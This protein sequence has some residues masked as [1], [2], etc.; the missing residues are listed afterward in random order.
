M[1]E[2]LYEMIGGRKTVTAATEL[3]YKK[4][5]EDEELHHFF[6]R[7][8]MA[9]LRSRQIMFVSMI[10]GGRVYTGRIFMKSMPDPEIMVLPRRTSTCS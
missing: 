2:D 8:D 1:T 5:S 10:L 6:K 7:V 9:H 4:V 3:F